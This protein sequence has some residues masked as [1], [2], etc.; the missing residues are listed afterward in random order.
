MAWPCVKST[1]VGASFWTT[2]SRRVHG[3]GNYKD[4]RVCTV[5][6]LSLYLFFLVLILIFLWLSQPEPFL[7]LSEIW[8]GLIYKV[9]G[10]CGPQG[11]TCTQLQH[12]NLKASQQPSSYI[13]TLFTLSVQRT[14]EHKSI[15]HDGF[16]RGPWQRCQSRRRCERPRQ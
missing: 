10:M 1:S 2:R 16:L 12:R 8:N 14:N 5:C 3:Y 7:V 9:C 4:I 13:L 15:D 6:I 11:T